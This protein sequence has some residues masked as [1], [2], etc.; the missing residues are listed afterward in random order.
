MPDALRGA[1]PVRDPC[2]CTPAPAVCIGC[3]V[4]KGIGLRCSVADRMRCP[5]GLRRSCSGTL[6]L[7]STYRVAVAERFIMGGT[8]APIRPLTRRPAFAGPDSRVG[9]P[10]FAVAVGN[11]A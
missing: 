2:C 7:R 1:V 4:R 3:T 5:V 9:S 8:A 6:T 11:A 10:R